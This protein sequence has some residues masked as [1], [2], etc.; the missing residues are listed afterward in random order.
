MQKA[1]RPHQK[2]PQPQR[3]TKNTVRPGGQHGPQN[4]QA[5]ARATNPQCRK[6][7]RLL[8][9]RNIVIQDR[10]GAREKRRN[11]HHHRAQGSQP[12]TAPTHPCQTGA[13]NGTPDHG[14]KGHEP[15]SDR[16]IHM[17]HQRRPK[18]LAQR[19]NILNTRRARENQQHG[20]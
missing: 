13:T 11:G 3:L 16:K 5:E 8:Q 20:Q 12:E 7:Q 2:S 17:H 15:D 10:L 19:E 14:S 4:S 18:K 6:K 9:N 1:P